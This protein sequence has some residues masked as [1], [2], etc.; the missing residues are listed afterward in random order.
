MDKQALREYLEAQTK[1]AE[2][3]YGVEVTVYAAYPAPEKKHSQ[4]K[5]PNLREEN[6]QAFL[7]EIGAKTP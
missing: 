2:N 7:E 1:R 3:I 4:R 6:Y 5:I